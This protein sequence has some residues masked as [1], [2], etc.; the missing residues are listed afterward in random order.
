MI[1][2]IINKESY[3]IKLKALEMAKD[4]I[5]GL[6]KNNNCFRNPGGNPTTY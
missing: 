4:K 5:K 3:E 1:I 2:R 6:I